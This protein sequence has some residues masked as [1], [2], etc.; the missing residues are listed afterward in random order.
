[1]RCVIHN[2]DYHIVSIMKLKILLLA[3]FYLKFL[4]FF[5]K[6]NKDT[7]VLKICYK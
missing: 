6:N 4:C 2:P 3:A 7:F 5:I 1:M